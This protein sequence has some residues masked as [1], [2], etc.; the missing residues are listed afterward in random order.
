MQ[1]LFA[2]KD[3][4]EKNAFQYWQM[5]EKNYKKYKFEYDKL[6]SENE[7]MIAVC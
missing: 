6:D 5:Q 3:E 2:E 1:Q 7:A 4:E